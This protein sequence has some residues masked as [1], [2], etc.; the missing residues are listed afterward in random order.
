[1]V[2]QENNELRDSVRKMV[3]DYQRQIEFRDAENKNLSRR[4]ESD[5]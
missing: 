1:M 4:L 5:N 2:E 3:D